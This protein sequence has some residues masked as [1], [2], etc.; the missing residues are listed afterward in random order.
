MSKEPFK[1]NPARSRSRFNI[2]EDADREEETEVKEAGREARDV[3]PR[4]RQERQEKFEEEEEEDIVVP[5]RRR[6]HKEEKPE[7][8]NAISTTGS[9]PWLEYGAATSMNDYVGD[10]LKFNAKKG[11][12]IAGKDEVIEPG[13]ELVANMESLEVGWIKWEDSRPGP[14]RMGR[15]VDGFQP[16]TRK[17]LGD[18]NEADWPIDDETKEPQDPWKFTNNIVLANPEDGRLFTFT[19]SSQGGL[20]A[21]GVLC[22]GYGEVQALH[23]NEWPKVALAADS[24][25]HRKRAYGRIEYP[26]FDIV[27]WVPKDGGNATKGGTKKGGSKF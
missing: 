4:R 16:L 21:I 14:R 9:N 18:T 2:E 6:E 25:Q 8:S 1:Y 24:Y 5:R 20:N 12:Y 27:G 7:T 22:N 10:L 23:P 17:E 26:I 3:V 13:T 19:T 11:E 15:L